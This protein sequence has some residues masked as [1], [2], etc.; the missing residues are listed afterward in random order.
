MVDVAAGA[1]AVG[2]PAALRADVAD[3]AKDEMMSDDMPVSFQIQSDIQRR[4]EH[5]A[6]EPATP[7]KGEPK[8]PHCREKKFQVVPFSS[9]II[10]LRCGKIFDESLA[11]IGPESAT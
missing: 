9:L 6:T 1:A 5:Y 4:L 10:C 3:W 11:D 2:V 7:V 8:C